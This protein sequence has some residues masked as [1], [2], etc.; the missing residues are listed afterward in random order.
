E[1]DLEGAKQALRMALSHSPHLG[2]VRANLA[3]L[4]LQTKEPEEAR[5][6]AHWVLTVD[7]RSAT[8]HR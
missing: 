2:A 7:P 6:D 5:K 8:A 4:E 3:A 1:N